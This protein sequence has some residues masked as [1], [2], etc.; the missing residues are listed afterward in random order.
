MEW[1]VSAAGPSISAPKECRIGEK[2]K[3]CCFKETVEF[4]LTLVDTSRDLP[5]AAW[6]SED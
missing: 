2:Q 6:V 1:I 3:E 5:M 4:I